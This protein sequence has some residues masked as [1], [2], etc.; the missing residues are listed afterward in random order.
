MHGWKRN[1]QFEFSIIG[2][3]FTLLLVYISFFG[4]DTHSFLYLK[5]EFIFAFGLFILV[6]CLKILSSI[7]ATSIFVTLPP[8]FSYPPVL[9]HCPIFSIHPHA[10]HDRHWPHAYSPTLHH[11][12]L[13]LK[14]SPRQRL[15]SPFS[16]HTYLHGRPARGIWQHAIVLFSNLFF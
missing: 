13:P 3:H 8:P 1:G 12:T 4:F 5:S 15:P 10:F 7:Q 16:K 6:A 14:N 11:S 2:P 9:S